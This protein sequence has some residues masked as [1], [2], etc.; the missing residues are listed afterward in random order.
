MIIELVAIDVTLVA[1]VTRL[2]QPHDQRL[3]KTVVL[4]DEVVE[5]DGLEIPFA[6][7][8]H[9]PFKQR[10]FAD[11]GRTAKYKR[12]VDLEPWALHAVRQ[13]VNAVVG[14][15]GIYRA[16]VVNPARCL[17]GI[18]MCYL[19]SGNNLFANTG[20]SLLFKQY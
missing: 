19:L 5:F 8:I 14:V 16:P 9:N 3:E 7:G 10:V 17:R 20:A 1:H 12:V 13:P 6:D 4:A 18:G 11:L 15:V 2:A